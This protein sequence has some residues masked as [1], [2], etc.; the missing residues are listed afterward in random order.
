MAIIGASV[1]NVFII[2]TES[3]KELVFSEHVEIIKTALRSFSAIIWQN[4]G[5]YGVITRAQLKEMSRIY[6]INSVPKADP[7]KSHHE[8]KI[9][10]DDCHHMLDETA[11]H[12]LC[13]EHQLDNDATD[14]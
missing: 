2:K 12:L 4:H 14:Q 8:P 13:R 9:F 5:L 6:T 1:V 3:A 10:W 11:L 7:E